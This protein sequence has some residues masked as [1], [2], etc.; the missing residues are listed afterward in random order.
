MIHQDP[1][2]LRPRTSR[3]RRVILL[4]VVGLILLLLG[5]R[6]IA[7]FWTDY[8]WFDS[9]ELNDVWRTLTL[10]K[11]WLVLVA[12]VVAAVLIWV[13]LWLADRLSLATC[14]PAE[15]PRTSCSSGGTSGWA[16]GRGWSGSSSPSGSG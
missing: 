4:V 10:T 16:P 9:L 11:V 2:P 7:T 6:S 1:V 14:S 15:D 13:N 8:L 3:R 5:L 12:T